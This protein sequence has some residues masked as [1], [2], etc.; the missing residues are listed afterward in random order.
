[1]WLK[2]QSLEGICKL[3][4][5]P[6][7]K[8]ILLKSFYVQ[9]RPFPQTLVTSGLKYLLKVGVG[10]MGILVGAMGILVGTMGILLAIWL[11]LSTLF[12]GV[13]HR[14]Y[15]QLFFTVCNRTYA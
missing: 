14:S 6:Y 2:V 13:I 11:E 12:L 8:L 10:A 1:M 4:R 7:I 9:K 15:P 3:E 5:V